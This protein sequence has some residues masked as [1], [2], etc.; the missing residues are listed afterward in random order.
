MA[1]FYD[2]V[3]IYIKAGNGGNGCIS[4]RRE[5]YVSHGGP[6][7]G[8]GGH[9]GNIVF[10]IDEGTN[11]LLDFRN[12]KKFVAQNGGDG[13]AAKFHGATAPDLI[14]PVPDGTVIR[15]AETGKVIKDMNPAT[16]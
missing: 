8:D 5:K 10:V 2:H 11:T 3:K 15:D 6:D 1:D 14:I 4:F 7:G 16:L 12:R 9:G 13:A